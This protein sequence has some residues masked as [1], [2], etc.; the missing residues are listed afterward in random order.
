MWLFGSMQRATTI[1]ELDQLFKCICQ[2]LLSPTTP[3]LA[4][5]VKQDIEP[6]EEEEEIPKPPGDTAVRWQSY[7]HSTEVGKHFERVKQSVEKTLGEIHSHQDE[8]NSNT[9]FCPSLLEYFLSSVM[10]LAPLWA[11]LITD[12]PAS[13][14]CVE[15]WM[16][17]V[18]HQLLQGKKRLPP[19]ELVEVIL[20]DATARRKELLI[21]PQ[22]GK[23]R[24][25]A[26]QGMDDAEER[27]KP[28]A[29]KRKSTYLGKTRQPSGVT[30]GTSQ[31]ASRPESEPL[32]SPK[33]SAATVDVDHTLKE[34]TSRMDHVISQQTPASPGSSDTID[35]D[36]LP[37][38]TT[39]RT[40]HLTSQPLSGVVDADILP[41]PEA[42]L[43]AQ[44]SLT[45]G[46][47]TIY[48][49][50]ICNLTREGG[51][52]PSDIDAWLSSSVISGDAL[53]VANASCLPLTVFEATS[54]PV[55]RQLA[56][57]KRLRRHLQGRYQVHESDGWI[58]P[59]N[60]QRYT[61]SRHWVLFAVDHKKNRILYL[62]SL[63]QKPPP[64][65]LSDIMA[66]VDV[67]R[68]HRAPWTEWRLVIPDNG[69]RQEDA[70]SCG[71]I[72]CLHI[73]ALC[74]GQAP[75]VPDTREA[76]QIFLDDE[77]R[78]VMQRR[79]KAVRY[80]IYLLY[81]IY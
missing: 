45:I 49:T 55:M 23:K 75:R 60:L 15:S 56:L 22:S 62:D 30:L 34:R 37:R 19:G 25:K 2:L 3:D 72:V 14:A 46:N 36:P 42:S 40:V 47:C 20:K 7:R 38:E 26:G 51:R 54:L 65:A 13:N 66:L 81:V 21:P 73:D 76:A 10:P 58:V 4:I 32:A 68:G 24:H 71:V 12:G 53:I 27:W 1:G 16:K 18:K 35:V 78:Q 44:G 69:M 80:T 63:Q 28:R 33:V 74:S 6:E 70:R 43:A 39:P 17:T 57:S 79:L 5:T 41:S 64:D 11:Q 59:F 67:G 48:V 52:W 77:Y 9:S 8:E 50:D 31:V 29:K 61:G